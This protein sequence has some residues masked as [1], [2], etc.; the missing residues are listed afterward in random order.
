MEILLDSLAAYLSGSTNPI[1]IR[2]LSKLIRLSPKEFQNV[3]VVLPPIDIWKK[4]LEKEEFCFS[5]FEALLGTGNASLANL[6]E[7]VPSSWKFCNVIV[8]NEKVLLKMDRSFV[9]ENFLKKILTEGHKFESATNR[10]TVKIVNC[11]LSQ[12]NNQ[13]T[14]VFSQLSEVRC[15]QVC[16]L[17]F[18]C[19]ATCKTYISL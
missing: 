17:N 11:E 3:D 8:Q 2:K 14:A 13:S 15:N 9:M 7:A 16:S 10:K 19:P 6:N 4:C 1:L 12:N 18:F 5:N